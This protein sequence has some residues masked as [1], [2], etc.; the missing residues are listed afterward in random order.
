MSAASQTRVFGI[1]IG[2]DPKIFVGGLFAVALLLFFV[3]G[4]SD[5]GS[6]SGT[7]AP[8]ST[9]GVANA[10]QNF[11]GNAA[12]RQ[13]HKRNRSEAAITDRGVLRIRPVD[14]TR[15]DIDPTLRMDM[16]QRLKHVP[17]P[18]VGRSLFEVGE[19]APTLEAIQKVNQKIVPG[20]VQ[21]PS[22]Q[23]AAAAA[24]AAAPH[25]DIPL[26]FYGFVK[27]ARRSASSRGL[28]LDGDNVVVASE[29]DMI[30][31]RYLVV[32]LTAQDARMEDT[33]MKQGQT[34]PVVPEA[35]H[36]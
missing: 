4:R 31:G 19:A 16:L 24:A 1:K 9:S 26:K 28:F 29:G 3:Y 2:V 21:P 17:E 14:A 22:P 25:A 30:N 10:P 7:P 27:T 36:Q 12:T 23:M 33:Q 6:S 35:V 11:P 15:G 8:A 18:T 34:L 13:Q 20:L 32:T 5:T